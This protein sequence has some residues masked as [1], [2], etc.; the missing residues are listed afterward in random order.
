MLFGLLSL[1]VHLF[2]A[3]FFWWALPSI[4]LQ[5]TYKGVYKIPMCSLIMNK[6]MKPREMSEPTGTHWKL[7]CSSYHVDA[8]ESDDSQG[9]DGCEINSYMNFKN[10]SQFIHIATN[11]IIL[12]F[13]MADNC[14]YVSPLYPFLCRWTF[15]CFQ[16]LAIVNSAAINIGV[17]VSFWTMLFS[18]YM[19]RDRWIIS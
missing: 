13:L 16:V 17:H 12:F 14:I 18:R 5:L 15:S 19:P 1:S 8:E 3:D 7:P 9:S 6:N 11:G 2:K 10:S 4:H